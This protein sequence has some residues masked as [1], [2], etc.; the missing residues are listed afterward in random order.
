MDGE[1]VGDTGRSD[2]IEVSEVCEESVDLC[3]GF[4]T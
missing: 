4:Q 3:P 1:T 2:I